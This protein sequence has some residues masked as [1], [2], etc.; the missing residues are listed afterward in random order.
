MTDEAVKWYAGH[1]R[2]E[3][4][5]AWLLVVRAVEAG[6][7]ADL[8]LENLYPGAYGWLSSTVDERAPLVR[9]RAEELTGASAALADEVLRR[10]WGWPPRSEGGVP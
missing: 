10:L 3:L 5:D 6:Y 7:F 8:G 2:E 4:A 1:L 9:A